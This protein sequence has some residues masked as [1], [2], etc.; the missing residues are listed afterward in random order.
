MRRSVR[1][2]F[3]VA[4]MMAATALLCLT[5]CEKSSKGGGGGGGEVP[6]ANIAGI[7]EGTYAIQGFGSVPTILRLTQDGANVSGNAGGSGTVRV[8]GTVEGDYVRLALVFPSTD[9]TD[10]VEGNVNGNAMVLNGANDKHG[11]SVTLNLT[12]T[13]GQSVESIDQSQDLEEFVRQ[14]ILHFSEQ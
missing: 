8:S 4:A 1:T 3:T 11:G 13:S 5:G 12:R 14:A 10:H 6:L 2:V 7:W 9:S